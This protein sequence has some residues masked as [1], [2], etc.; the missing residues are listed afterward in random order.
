MK[1]ISL[2]LIILLVMS[3]IVGCAGKDYE[4]RSEIQSELRYYLGIFEDA[5]IKNISTDGKAKDMF[6]IKDRYGDLSSDEENII[7]NAIK[8]G[9]NYILWEG[10]TFDI[11]KI[12]DA[13]KNLKEFDKGFKK[14]I[15]YF[16]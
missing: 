8:L 15:K 14:I 11:P 10:Y 13:N 6:T 7:D 4:I 16:K 3:N 9:K 1:K 5:R 2:V 12:E